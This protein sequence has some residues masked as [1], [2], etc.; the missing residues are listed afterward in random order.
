MKMKLFAFLAAGLFAGASGSAMA[1]QTVTVGG[2]SVTCTNQCVVTT[3][4]NGSTQVRD[5]CGG[6]VSGTIRRVEE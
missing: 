6:R 4:S 2:I 3:G 5:C 1:E